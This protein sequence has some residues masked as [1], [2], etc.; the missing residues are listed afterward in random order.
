MKH[1]V[2]RGGADD[3]RDQRIADVRA[4]KLRT[5]EI[6]MWWYGIHP[7]HILDLR[8]S[9]KDTRNLRAERSGNTGDKHATRSHSGRPLPGPDVMLR[10]AV[11]H[12]AT[13][14]GPWRGVPLADVSPR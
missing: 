12:T 7:D 8:I 13:R 5:P 1:G 11:V 4:D 10:P 6:A 9:R 14:R 2:D 3:L